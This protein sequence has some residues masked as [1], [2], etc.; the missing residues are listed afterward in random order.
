MTPPAAAAA[1]AAPARPVTV[2]RVEVRARSGADDPRGRAA[3]RAARAA[4]GPNLPERIDTAAVYLIEGPLDEKQAQRIADEIL[5]DPVTETVTLGASPATADALVEVHP[6]P[7][8]MEPD[9]ESIERAVRAVLGVEVGV[10]TGRR[11]DLHGIDPAAARVLAER[12]FANTVIHGIHDAPFHPESLPHGHAR[13]MI[14]PEVP[15]REL[16]DAALETLSREAH[17]FLSLEELQAIRAEYRRAGRDPREIELETLAQTWSEHCVHKTLKARIRYRQSDGATERR[18]DE[19]EPRPGGADFDSLPLQG[20]GGGGGGPSD[21]RPPS[22]RAPTEHPLDPPPHSLPGREGEAPPRRSV[23]IDWSARPGHEVQPDGSVVIHNLLKSTIAAATAELMADGID[24]C[25]SVFVDNA[26]VI[27]FDD[28][29]AVCFKCETH[30]H[31]S[32]LEPYGGAATGIGGCIRDIIGTGLAAR[33]IAATDVF[34]V[35]W[36]GSSPSCHDDSR[37]GSADGSSESCPTLPAGCLHPRRI[38]TQVVAGVRDYG[39]RMG[40]PTLNGAVWF[41][42]DYVGNPLVYCGCVGVMPRDKVHGE[43]EP[44]DVIVALGGRTGRD[45]IHG[46]T[47]S[48][49]ELTD[50]HAD[51]FSH[52]VQIGNPVTEKKMLDAILLAR[53]HADGCLYRAIT[54]CGAGG[55]SS[56]VGEM[57]ET[58][59]AEVNLEQAPLK[60]AGLSPTEIWISEAQERMVLAV[61]RENLD[62]L[63]AICDEHEVELC[64][65]GTF[66]TPDRALVLRYEGE[67]VGRLS[68]QFLH[69]GL[70]QTV[71]EAIWVGQVSDLPSEVEQVSNLPSAVGQVSDLP[72]PTGQPP[73]RSAPHP[74]IHRLPDP[75]VRHDILDTPTTAPRPALRAR[76][77]IPRDPFPK[78]E[79]PPEDLMGHIRRLPHMELAE[80]TYFLTWRAREGVTL[81][82][83]ERD[84][85]L[86]ALTHWEGERCQLYA[87][88][89]MPDH[90]HC[91]LRPLGDERLE[92][93]V[94]GIKKF[95]AREISQARGSSGPLWQDERFDH[96]V[97]DEMWFTEFVFYIVRNAVE[98]GLVARPSEYAWCVVHEDILTGDGQSIVRD[99]DARRR[100][101]EEEKGRAAARRAAPPEKGRA[102]ARRAAP[103]VKDALLALLAHPNI[104]SKHWIIRQYDHEVQ[105]RSVVT[106]LVGPAGIGPSDAAVILPVEGSTRGIAIANGLAT[107]LRDDPY[108]M[109]LAAIDECV[110]NLVCV[111]ADP[112]RIA[113]LDNFC[114]PSCGDP[115]QLGGLVRAA[116]A[117]YDAAKAYKTPFISGKDS[118]NNQFTTDDGRTIRIP[119]TL[120]ISGFGIVPDVSRCVTMDA[121]QAGNGLMWICC[122]DWRSLRGS[123]YEMIFGQA[124]RLRKRS[125]LGRHV[126]RGRDDDS[127][128]LP[129]TDLAGG[130]AAARF[131]YEAI[132]DGLVC[133]AHDVSDGGLLVAAAEM[134]MAGGLGLSLGDFGKIVPE[135]HAT[136]GLFGEAPSCYLLEVPE[137]KFEAMHARLLAISENDSLGFV[138]S[139]GVFNDSGRLT[140]EHGPN[141]LDVSLD[142]CI[143]AW[144]GA[145]DW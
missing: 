48:S 63:Q 134:A 73:D 89:V 41:D 26:G 31:P 58:L 110:R 128:D 28:E 37:S 105:G 85:V 86:G 74:Q 76:G 7:G 2:H 54:D 131:V 103:P 13:A 20:E 67:E 98:A 16:D 115:A 83:T 62:T 101:A 111:G 144:R 10:H 64:A 71:R 30:N 116:E 122:R 17:L 132:R 126:D 84:I 35:A 139:I 49:A 75:P 107:G 129:L 78:G 4:G 23:R 72:S 57:G 8:V 117:C 21:A 11:Y 142:E 55:F 91:L 61:P 133:S 47:F 19:G 118:L 79:R 141:T 140:I 40:I 127:D 113:L 124:A 45:G 120:L 106:P 87:A 123:H 29:H 109:A 77:F 14:V 130:P 9:A 46:A 15:I 59:G 44:G 95:T 50:T 69:E 135:D 51:E 119:P 32:A 5:A 145:L 114:W 42:D 68:M 143:A 33:P 70:P 18:S 43:P 100:E 138:E 60:Y 104:A 136:A 97:R 3:L 66:G 25:L 92:K 108:V 65:L 27:A 1:A 52:A 99:V 12:V 96:I 90:V 112:S 24:W 38:L 125:W 36:R 82:E 34:C 6:L 80:A 39:N 22:D 121:K 53:D 94:G 102:A 88:C 81:S 137:S 56:A 93:L